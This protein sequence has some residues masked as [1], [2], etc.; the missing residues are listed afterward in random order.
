VAVGKAPSL[1]VG[2]LIAALFI[3]VLVGVGFWLIFG[4]QLL[5]A[6]GIFLAAGLDRMLGAIQAPLVVPG[7]Q[8]F[9][10]G[11]LC[12]VMGALL[13]VASWKLLRPKP[14]VPL[15]PP[16]ARTSSS[17]ESPPAW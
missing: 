14:E 1:T 6:G 13:L 15:P 9:I 17:S 7:V 2:V 10:L 4:G 5:A 16:P 3:V 8:P 12:L 11:G